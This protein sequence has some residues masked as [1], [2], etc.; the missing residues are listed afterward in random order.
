MAEMNGGEPPDPGRPLATEA[1]GEAGGRASPTV[2]TDP[3][4]TV[5]IDPS[6]T[7]TDAV[8]AQ[9]ETTPGGPEQ[10]PGTVWTG[11][12]A[13]LL[14]APVRTTEEQARTSRIV[15]NV[16]PL[17]Q[18]KLV[19]TMTRDWDTYTVA[20]WTDEEREM[21]AVAFAPTEV[22]LEQNLRSLTD[23][24]AKV[25]LAYTRGDL[26]L[27]H[28]PNFVKAT[29][30]P[31]HRAMLEDI[32]EAHFNATLTANLPPSVNLRHNPRVPHQELFKILYNSN[33]DGTIGTAMMRSL[34]R[35]LKRLTYDGAHT[36]RFVFYSSRLAALWS[37][38][39]LRFQRAVITLFD[40]TRRA[41][42]DAA[43]CYTD[44]QLQQMFALHVYGAGSMG[45]T[46][47]A[48]AL[49]ALAG[50]PVLDV[51]YPRSTKTDIY[52]NRYHV[53]RFAQEECP[54][55]LVGVTRVTLP[56][57]EAPL[58]L[59]HF[60]TNLRLPCSHC[61]SSRHGRS[62]CRMSGA[63]L[64]SY[65]V[66]C[67]RIVTGRVPHFRPADLGTYAVADATALM[68]ILAQHAIALKTNEQDLE[69]TA[70]PERAPATSVATATR[71]LERPAPTTPT[72]TEVRP[73]PSGPDAAGYTIVRRGGKSARKEPKAKAPAAVNRLSPASTGQKKPSQKVRFEDFKRAEAYGHYG[74]LAEED[75]DE[76]V[77]DMPA[78]NGGED[79]DMVAAQEEDSAGSP[80]MAYHDDQ[81]SPSQ[82]MEE[83]ADEDMEGNPGC[84]DRP[85]DGLQPDNEVKVG[86][87]VPN[88]SLLDVTHEHVES[89]SITRNQQEAC[90]G[91][92]PASTQRE[93]VQTTM[94]CYMAA[95][96]QH[97]VSQRSGPAD[98]IVPETP[99]SPDDCWMGDTRTGTADGD[100]DLPIQLGQWLA[101][102]NGYEVSVEAN[103]QCAILS[104]YAMLSN[105]SSTRLPN[106]AAHMREAS[107]VKRG[108]YTLMMVNLRHD[109]ELGLVDPRQEYHRLY[110]NHPHEGSTQA[111]TAA[112][113]AH[114]AR[115][116]ER[117]ADVRVPSDFWASP[118]ELRAMAQYLRAPVLVIDVTSSGDGHIQCYM[119]K[120][121]R[122]RSGLDHETGC[123]EAMTDRLAREYL[124]HCWRLHVLPHILT[125]H[126]QE[127]HFYGVAHGEL[128][129]RWRAEGDPEF[130]ATVP[131]T[132]PWK[133]TV[134]ILQVGE[135]ANLS[136]INR[137]ADL[138]EVNA[139][140]IKRLTMRER[141]DVV[142]ARLG[143]P[144][145]DAEGYDDEEALEELIRTETQ[146]LQE[147][148]G[149]DGYVSGSQE[150]TDQDALPELPPRYP[151]AATGDLTEDSHFR[152]LRASTDADIED[153][154][155]PQLA[156]LK[157]AN[158]EAFGR[159]CTLYRPTLHVP[160]TKR[161]STPHSI[162]VWLLDNHRSL[163]HLFAFLPY[164]ELEAKCWPFADLMTWGAVE[165]FTEQT[166]A[167]R[168]IVQDTSLPE[169]ARGYCGEW[170]AAIAAVEGPLTYQL[171]G[172]SQRWLRLTRWIKADYGRAQPTEMEPQV[173]R[174]IH[175][176]PYVT[177]N[178]TS[179]PMGWAPQG[180]RVVWYS[181][182]TFLRTLCH[183]IMDHGDWSAASHA[184]SGSM[185]SDQS[186]S[187]SD[188]THPS[189]Y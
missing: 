176:L 172:D 69:L 59:H 24:E 157:A 185:W 181:E 9:Q 106:T 73:K 105:H 33:T 118:H 19:A 162:S 95:G 80:D 171:A 67:S 152:L 116:R 83:D 107:K 141:L 163:R 84:L 55:A 8:V 178:W 87:Q 108:V 75:S 14:S 77:G 134:N 42:R 115:E 52:D 27:P 188:R 132:F 159:W 148:Y 41:G 154:D 34:L 62:R 54:A 180:A 21:R 135:D 31:L 53:V 136:T 61:Y 85:R 133:A 63:Q 100:Q 10:Q 60:Q 147:D 71:G 101:S 113:M 20:T 30:E 177:S 13:E 189:H 150:H 96:G 86:A 156:L 139:I 44:A 182:F 17:L 109:V 170:L 130:T 110:P 58:I 98:A 131:D 121:E 123:Y 149:I 102:F 146:L 66:R 151:R 140:L 124:Y 104:L 74:A 12:T 35:D 37:R 169:A 38:Q 28:P 126:H 145:L 11:N 40:T 5:P 57:L 153:I 46:T 81:Q 137:L 120:D 183:G 92:A 175:V 49:T 125:I 138:P 94:A 93:L 3:T 15:V 25:L 18:K 167:L 45:L 79:V 36:L 76:E 50:V 82:T 43:G 22:R 16:N 161:R 97:N 168:R 173:W 111:A 78:A 160:D 23:S 7:A 90:T 117:P 142:H 184:P 48:R 164:P 186:E 91:N 114:Y 26:E 70:A 89:S 2:P 99:A 174:L 144:I 179:T 127:R 129:V 158:Q 165:V 64:E 6:D 47:L 1:T 4:A 51:E 119:Y 103:G 187:S 68:E 72:A 143:L 112:L 122:L 166:D 65:R 32:H 56:E 155:R 39:T 88:H 29:M 128:Y